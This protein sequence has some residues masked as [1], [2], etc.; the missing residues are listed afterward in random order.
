MSVRPPGA[1]LGRLRTEGRSDPH[2]AL[3]DKD[4]HVRGTAADALGK[5]Q[6]PRT[7]PALVKVIS[8]AG[9]VPDVRA[10]AAQAA[11]EC[12]DAHALLP[13]SDALKGSFPS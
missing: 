11:G 6:D 3:G 10:A 9:E 1:V 13:L 2:R 8:T 5:H 4:D 7:L 12:G